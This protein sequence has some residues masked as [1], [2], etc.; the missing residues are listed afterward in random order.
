MFIFFRRCSEEV[1]KNTTCDGK[2][3]SN[4]QKISTFYRRGSY[5]YAAIASFI[6]DHYQAFRLWFVSPYACLCIVKH[7]KSFVKHNSLS[8]FLSRSDFTHFRFF[9]WIPSIFTVGPK[10][11]MHYIRNEQRH[12]L[13]SQNKSRKG[14]LLI[15]PRRKLLLLSFSALNGIWHPFA[16]FG[17]LKCIWNALFIRCLFIR[18]V[19]RDYSR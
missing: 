13:C 11:V 3:M 17:L 9:F 14:M 4:F 7:D 5:R 12:F 8:F 16:F 18:S 19:L 1:S 10:K 15:F 6:F 2:L